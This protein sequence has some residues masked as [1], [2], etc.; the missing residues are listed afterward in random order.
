MTS[1]GSPFFVWPSSDCFGNCIFLKKKDD[2]GKLEF[3]FKGARIVFHINYTFRGCVKVFKKSEA[4]NTGPSPDEI[5]DNHGGDDS[6]EKI[7][8]YHYQ[9]IYNKVLLTAIFC[10]HSHETNTAPIP[11]VW[12]FLE[13][14][15]YSG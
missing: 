4:R 15:E 5:C 12:Y 8:A 9:F 10:C 6:S 1:E 14:Y 13:C 11:V 2:L 3:F 7:H